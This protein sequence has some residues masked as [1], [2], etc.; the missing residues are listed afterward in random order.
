MATSDETISIER[1][2]DAY[3]VGEVVFA[4]A[5]GIGFSKFDCAQIMSAVVE[6]TTNTIKHAKE[7]KVTVRTL[8]RGLE[9]IVK[10]EGPGIKDVEIIMQEGY[11]TKQGSLGIGLKAARRA[12]DEFQ[13][14]SQLGKGTVV[15]MQKYLAIPEE[16]IEYGVISLPK[17]EGLKN[18]DEYVVKEYNG[19][20]VLLSVIDG[21]G[22]GLAAHE[23]GIIAKDIIEDN[24]RLPLNELMI[25]IH[26][27]LLREK[28]R[29]AVVVLCRLLPNSLEYLGLGDTEAM[30][31]AEGN[32]AVFNR[33]GELGK[34][35]IRLPDLRPLIF[36]CPRK[37][38]I[39]I[40]SDGI[41]K[42]FRAEDLP[43]EKNAQSI[44][45]FILKNFWRITD[46]GTVLVACR[47]Q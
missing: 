6:V 9:I 12:M 29:G 19:D 47:K 37:V 15:V 41:K 1:E 28:G 2:Q 22:H 10:D 46:D 42:R 14:T 21:E 7:G 32:L 4:L 23:A 33:P 11:T 27:A 8:E 18:G 43:L 44:A 20:S 3:K 5:K 31:I 45:D 24:Y 35:Q 36:N 38:V 13:I 26:E 39:V 25:K 17:P 16:V 40:F 30:V 34:M